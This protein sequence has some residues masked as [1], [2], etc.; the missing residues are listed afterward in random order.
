MT[1]T[2]PHHC[3]CFILHQNYHDEFKQHLEKTE[4]KDPLLQMNRGQKFGLTKRIDEETQIHVKQLEN[5]VIESEMEYPPDYPVAHLNQK[6]CSSAHHE[7]KEVFKIVQ[8]PHKPKFIPPLSCLQPKIIP[9]INPSHAKAIAG[10]A[11][12]VGIVGVL[13]YAL[14]KEVRK[15]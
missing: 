12:V 13:L 11:V 1:Q 3:H 6:H 10:G 15:E 9:A 8:I 2:D 14:T 5:G 4:F 7:L